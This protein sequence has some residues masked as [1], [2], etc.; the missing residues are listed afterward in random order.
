MFN[1][2]FLSCSLVPLARVAGVILNGMIKLISEGD[3]AHKSM[4]YTVI[5]QLGQRIP[6]LINK[7]LSL[8]HNL[9]DTLVSVSIRFYTD[10]TVTN[11]QNK[12]YM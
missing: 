10:Y 6:S 2:K 9:F 11:C 12:H 5:G 3:D 1:F 7:D 4:A 8:L